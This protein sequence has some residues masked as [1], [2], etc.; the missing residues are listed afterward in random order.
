MPGRRNRHGTLMQE[1]GEVLN[2]GVVGELGW[3]RLSGQDA[4]DASRALFAKIA[5]NRKLDQIALS[6]SSTIIQTCELGIHLP[7]RLQ[8]LSAYCRGNREK[9]H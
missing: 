8:G 7:Y 3:L 2:T 1:P 4:T 9:Q 6:I 5:R